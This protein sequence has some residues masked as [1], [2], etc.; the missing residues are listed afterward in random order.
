MKMKM[1]KIIVSAI[2]A[3]TLAGNASAAELFTAPEKKKMMQLTLDSF[4]GKAR[5]SKG[6]PVQ[7]KDDKERNTLPISTA[8]ANH[9]IDKGAES[10]LAQWC[11]VAWQER[12]QL[13]IAQLQKGLTSDTQV[14]YAG[15]LHGLAQ[16]TM[17]DSMKKEK[18]DSD[19]R[20]Q[21]QTLMTDDIKNLKRSLATQ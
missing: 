18:C 5:D 13:I 6:Q 2:L 11:D 16:H 7:P 14:A 10:G 8:Q 4:W 21:M 9:I 12:Y 1:K 20:E 3:I 15:V 17:L 19:T